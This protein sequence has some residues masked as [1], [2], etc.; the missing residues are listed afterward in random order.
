MP[1]LVASTCLSWIFYD[2]AVAVRRLEHHPQNFDVPIDRRGVETSRQAA[3][4]SD[5]IRAADRRDIH[6]GALA[7]E[8]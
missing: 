4:P 6:V 3:A 1:A 8:R 5:D 7:E 2:E